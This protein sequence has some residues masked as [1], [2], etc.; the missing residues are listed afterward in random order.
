ML[1]VEPVLDVLMVWIDVIQDCICVYLM[2]GREDNNLEMLVGLFE[3]FHYVRANVDTSVDR[4]LV[5]EI[6]LQNDIRILSLNIVN[7]VDQSL[8][9]VEYDEFLLAF[10]SWRWKVDDQIL[11]F[12]WFDDSDIVLYKLQSLDSLHEVL[13]VEILLLTWLRL[14]ILLRNFGHE[15]VQSI[16]RV[17]WSVIVHEH[18]VPLSRLD[19]YFS[20][21]F[22]INLVEAILILILE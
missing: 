2:T 13:L 19:A 16:V 15:G 5:W 17:A 9:H 22:F 8:I 14:L 6:N 20:I 4:L 12:F 11:H 1:S 3:T 7:A 21:I 10:L 18:W